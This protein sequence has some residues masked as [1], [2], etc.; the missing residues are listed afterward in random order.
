MT[1]ATDIVAYAYQAD[2]WC[3]PCIR[4]VA[5][6]VNEANGRA[7]DYV[8]LDTLLERWAE[9]EGWDIANED[10][11]TED[12]PWPVFGDQLHREGDTCGNCHDEL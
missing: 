6:N 4:R 9:I 11:D 10:I 5:A 12:Y 1:N 7:A 2:L 8:P 3:L